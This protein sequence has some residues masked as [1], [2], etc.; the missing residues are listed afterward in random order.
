MCMVEINRA[1]DRGIDSLDIEILSDKAAFCSTD[2]LRPVN[3]EVLSTTMQQTKIIAEYSA[4]IKAKP[5]ADQLHNLPPVSV[6]LISESDSEPLWD[7]LVRSYHYLGYQRLIGHRLKYMAF[8]ENQPV[9]ALSWSAP[10]LKLA[11]RDQFIGWSVTQ[12]K[13][14]L[15]QLAS[16]SRFL[17]P[18]WV[19]IANLASHVLSLN[20]EQ[21]KKDWQQHF[22]KQL[23][24]LE[25]FV[26]SRYFKGTCYKAANWLH[27]GD[28]Y[29]SGKQGKGYCYH[30]TPKEI[31]LYVLEPN[32]RSIIGCRQKAPCLFHCPPPTKIK[33]EELVMLLEHC[34]WHPQLVA[35]LG[36]D[37][38]DVKSLAQQLVEFHQQFHDHYGRIEHQ[39]LGLAYISG[40]MSN[41]QAKSVEPIAL[42][43][44]NKESVR[45]LQMFMKNYRWDHQG[46][47]RAHQSMLAQMIGRPNGMITIDSC[48]FPKKGKES[49]GVARQYC[50]PLGK[51]E[52]CQSGVFVGYSSHAGYGLLNCQLYMPESWFSKEQQ[53]RRKANMVPQKLVFQTK[54][55]I[56]GGLI[57]Q[58][59]ATG[60]FPT[61]WLGCDATFGTDNDF[62]STLPSDLYYFADIR[63]DTLVFTKKPR[64]GLPPYK[65]RGRR[66]SKLKVLAGQ[67]KVKS[68][69]DIAASKRLS[70]K[71]VIVAEGAKGPIVA[72]VARIQVYLARDG[73]PV[74][75][76]QWLFLRK[77][78]DGKIKYAIS[79]APKQIPFAELIKASTMRW[80]IEQCF[81]E[82]KGQL[83]MDNYEHRSWPAWHRHMIYVFLALHFLL[84]MRLKFKKNSFADATASSPVARCSTSS[85]IA[86][87][88]GNDGNH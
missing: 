85:E 27:V 40:L 13:R 44:L 73:L 20:I 82:G 58:V 86:Q 81:Q 47:Q 18:P 37:E 65:G 41:S 30:G 23:L 64:I 83:G 53:K 51:V 16:N 88:E 35:E 54:Q 72:K 10:A 26:D 78:T 62:L 1:I 9:A 7:Q 48:E 69:S 28:T 55:Q 36:L 49:V 32:F 45:S 59:M 11:A 24:V 3:T 87:L 22:N 52:N 5:I 77:N 67:P 38:S 25:T 12:R 80:P 43:L 19:K 33:V 15:N 63:C 4:P 39:R 79:N 2:L 60:D 71:S 74:G 46:I 17:I 66:P 29:G 68:V 8:I 6:K 42:E 57:E 34:Q 21:L 70:W 76:R 84:R 75:D 56:A 14:H 61:R 50:G 31:Y